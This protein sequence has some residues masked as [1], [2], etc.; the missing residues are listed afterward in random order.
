MTNP[1]RTGAALAAQIL[2]AAGLILA[3][4]A[5][6][7]SGAA[8][9]R[10]L[11]WTA[12]GDDGTIGRAFQYEVRYAT[13]PLSGTA[14][15]ATA[16]AWW[17]AAAPLPASRLRSPSLAGATD[18]ATVGNLTYGATYYFV[19]RAGDEA[20]NWSPLSNVA[21]AS[22]PACGAPS[23]APQA[24]QAAEDSGRVRLTWAAATDPAAT[25]LVI[26]RGPNPATLL[27]LATVTDP[28]ATDYRDTTTGVGQ[29]YYYVAAWAA[30]CGPGPF[31]AAISITRSGGA[32]GGGGSGGSG[33]T[34][35]ALD[36]S[37]HAYPNPSS[38]SV[39]VVITVDGT[40][41][42]PA[43]IRVFDMSGRWIADVASGTFSPGKHTVTW[44]RQNRNGQPVA[45]GYYEVL[46]T[47]GSVSVRER[48]VLLP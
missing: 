35:T 9:S 44:Q 39:N 36:H 17:S 41:S 30:P 46:G 29:T 24:F 16:A 42:V 15:S 21:T 19:M 38:G 3:A 34:T 18:S 7:Q 28:S 13:S 8:N 26:Y 11:L 2:A 4:P 6:A 12:P 20:Q 32:P 25:S 47:I 48:I 45:P 31:T 37:I 22:L 10:T 33:A 23:A 43:R 1:F 40:Q 14:D 5:S 27:P